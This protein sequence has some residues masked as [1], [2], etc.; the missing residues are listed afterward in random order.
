M[1]VYSSTQPCIQNDTHATSVLQRG[2]YLESMKDR[3]TVTAG[4]DI[5]E[6]VR[7][8]LKI[9]EDLDGISGELPVFG[10]QIV[11][12][13]H[14]FILFIGFAFLIIPFTIVGKAP[15]LLKKMNQLG[16]GNK[17]LFSLTDTRFVMGPEKFLYS[18]VSNIVLLH[19]AGPPFTNAYVNHS[20]ERF[21]LRE[22]GIERALLNLKTQ[23]NKVHL[24]RTDPTLHAEIEWLVQQIQARVTAAQSGAV[25]EALKRLTDMASE[26]ETSSE[27]VGSASKK[28]T[29]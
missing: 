2:A 21:T 29:T 12:F 23:E 7:E 17:V 24:W 27:P 28:Q 13:F 26:A 5:P 20:G 11:D 22:G 14:F 10:T 25:P 4:I 3:H 1:S 8:K 15:N 18:D 9:R 16:R 19:S 6:K